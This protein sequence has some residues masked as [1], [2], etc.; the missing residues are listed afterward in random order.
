MVT[1][2]KA[3]SR[4]RFAASKKF[5]LITTVLVTWLVNAAIAADSSDLPVTPTDESAELLE[6]LRAALTSL[7]PDY[8]PRTEHFNN[9][10]Q[11]TYINRLI[12]EKSPYLL[13]HAHNPVNWFPW[14][15][16]AFNRA[17][18]SNK[19][20]FLSV[21]YAT[22]H[23]CHVMERQ[24]FESEAI[25]RYMNEYFVTVKVDR[26]Q[27]PDVDSTFMTT[28]QTVSY[29]HLTLPTTPYV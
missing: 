26:E 20:I 1:T 21:G 7:G 2:K 29:T 5:L 27:R 11:P 3:E 23:W 6:V 15:E 10:Q 4:C 19:P 22:C 14:G 13:Q 17:K 12:L 18:E 28:V 8:K 25:A 9:N 16:E 24:S